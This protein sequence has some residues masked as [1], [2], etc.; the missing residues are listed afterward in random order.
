VQ[1]GETGAL[2]AAATDA[3]SIAMATAIAT[4]SEV[5]LIAPDHVANCAVRVIDALRHE[6]P[7]EQTLNDYMQAHGRL[8]GAM[9]I[10]LGESP[11]EAT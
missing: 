11:P 4:V 9:R 8:I 3:F 6:R 2:K 7:R 10:D 1:T 5:R